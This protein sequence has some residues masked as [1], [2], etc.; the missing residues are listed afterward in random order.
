[1][2][3]LVAEQTQLKGERVRM[4]ARKID[5]PCLSKSDRSGTHKRLFTVAR[6][7]VVCTI[8]QAA[9]WVYDQPDHDNPTR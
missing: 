8:E 7:S 1:M 3:T 9:K 2:A 4:V 6:G 5:P